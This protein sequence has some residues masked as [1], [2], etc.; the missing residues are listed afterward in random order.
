MKKAIALIVGLFVVGTIGAPGASAEPIDVCVPL[1]VKVGTI[2]VAGQKIPGVSDIKVCVRSLT[3]A[4]GEPQVRR[5]EGCGDTCLAVVIRNLS[6]SVDT[7]VNVFYSLDGKAQQPIPVSTGSTTVAP[8]DGVH[9]CVLGYSDPGAPNPCENGVSIPA[10]LKAAAGRA[11]ISLSWN[12]SFAFGEST[13]AGYEI[14]RSDTGTEGTFARIATTTSLS[15]SDIG[16]PQGTTYWYQIVAFDNE[17]TKS[18]A[19]TSASATAK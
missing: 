18:G 1:P 10:N 13:V 17:N 2:T 4:T 9:N 6:V 8:L 16:V 15:F 12:R 19:S 5:Y 7:T 3:E 14:W 11:K